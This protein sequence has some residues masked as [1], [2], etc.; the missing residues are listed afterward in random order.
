V[1]LTQPQLLAAVADRADC[2]PIPLIAHRLHRCW[3]TECGSRASAVAAGAAGR[4]DHNPERDAA[5]QSV[6]K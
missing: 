6:A 4:T 1:A 3:R 2:S 5:G